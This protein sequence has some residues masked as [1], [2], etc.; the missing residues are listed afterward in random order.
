MRHNSN[1]YNNDNL[2]MISEGDILLCGHTH[3]PHLIRKKNIFILTQSYQYLKKTVKI[4]T[5][6]NRR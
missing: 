5:D 2:P 1:K 3:I 4:V 6:Y